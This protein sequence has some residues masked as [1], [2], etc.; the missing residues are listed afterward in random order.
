MSNYNDNSG[1][2]G[3]SYPG[4]G[5]S[6]GG[7]SSDPQYGSQPPQG[8]YDQQGGYGQQA[9]GQPTYGQP[10]YAGQGGSEPMF[11]ILNMGQEQ[12][13]VPYSQLGQMAAA[14]ALKGETPVRDANTGAVLPAKQLPGVFSS[15]DWLTA[16][17]LSF[18]LGGL[19]VDRFYL[20]QIGLGI[21]KLV[22]LGACGIWSLIDFIMLLM[23]KINDSEGK[24]LA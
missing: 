18:F 21:L 12:G 11:F 20:G 5:E 10:Q 2:Y 14:G 4:N 24:P 8:N 9:Y 15:K 17:L 6:S 16:V 3:G 7:Q 23:H 19:G 13:P 1:G 22:T